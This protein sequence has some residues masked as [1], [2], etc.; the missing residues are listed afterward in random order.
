[1]TK[2]KND[3]HE[4]DLPTGFAKPAKRALARAGYVRLEQFTKLTEDEVLMLH[5]TGP[6]ALE[7]IRRSL[8]A[9]GQSFAI[10]GSPKTSST[11]SRASGPV[12]FRGT[13]ELGGK[14]ATG[15]EV[16]SEVVESLGPSK[17]PAVRV[18]LKAHT[19][20]TS[21]ASMRGK[22]ML[23]VSAEQR[24]RAGVA[25]GDV[26]DVDLELDTESREV[27]VPPDFADVLK[28]DA[29]ARRYFDGLS[30]SNRLRFVLSI[31]AAKTAETRQRRI[32]KAVS[33]LRKG[34]S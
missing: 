7:L 10:S 12:R 5:G 32:A 34:R 17:R 23:P 3:L 1:M 8:A 15:I 9:R 2:K 28:R 24:E 14:T 4:S 33:T 18:T 25:A 20:R 21:V 19:Y 29:D 16:P 13:L 11:Q 27:S 22:F 26:V 30:Y 31:E 6:K